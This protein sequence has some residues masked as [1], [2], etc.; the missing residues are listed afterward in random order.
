[1]LAKIQQYKDTWNNLPLKNSSKVLP[2]QFKFE[3]V[4]D[5]KQLQQVQRFRA[6][7]FSDQFGI[8]FDHGLDQDLYDFSCEHAV[9]K[10]RWSGEIVAYTRLKCL[11]GYELATQSYSETEFAIADQFSHLSNIVEIGRTCVH[12]QFRSGRALSMLWLHLL[13][14]VVW[15]MRAKH[16]MG[17]VS[18]RLQD[19]LARAYHTHQQLQQ[20]SASQIIHIQSKNQFIPQC[21]SFIAPQDEKLPKL[22][23]AYL[24]MQ[25]KLSQQ[26]YYDE[27]FN[28]L[29][30]FVFLD[31][32][33]IGKNFILKKMIQNH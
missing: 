5:I 11:Q 1:M 33:Q 31:M 10:E 27:E 29:D 12:P 30:Y 17:C 2:T 8:Q 3:W 6:R 19:N 4:D 23:D 13:P 7:Q 15:G 24:R 32:N 28:C 25:A 20:L 16:V 22:F 18:V 21:P 14:K 9:L 26:A